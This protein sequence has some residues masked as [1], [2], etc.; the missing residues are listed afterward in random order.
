MRHWREVNPAVAVPNPAMRPALKPGRRRARLSQSGH[1][2]LAM[3]VVTL[4]GIGLVVG[5]K[6]AQR[7]T[8][9]LAYCHLDPVRTQPAMTPAISGLPVP[10]GALATATLAQPQPR[11]QQAQ[12]LLRLERYPCLSIQF[13][14]TTH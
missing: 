13:I 12:A 11:N 14:S 4:A 2:A 6:E 3:A 5:R 10:T 8:Q 7:R 9:N 1:M